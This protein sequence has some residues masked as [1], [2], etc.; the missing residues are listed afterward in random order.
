METDWGILRL[1]C[2]WSDSSV[3][4]VGVGVV[5]TTGVDA[6]PLYSK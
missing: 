5:A 4:G 2:D 3:V 6:S 1:T